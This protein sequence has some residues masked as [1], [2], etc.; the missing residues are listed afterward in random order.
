MRRTGLQMAGAH[1]L[2]QP[3]TE[4]PPCMRPS[5]HDSLDLAERARIRPR[6]LLLPREL[7]DAEMALFSIAGRERRVAA[8]DLIF[9]RGELGR[10]MFVVDSGQ[11]QVEFGDGMPDKLIGP[12]EFFGELA[13]FIG[14]HAR[15]A[16]ARAAN[17]SVLRVIEVERDQRHRTN[18]LAKVRL[19]ALR[20]LPGGVLH[21]DVVGV[22]ASQLAGGPLPRQLAEGRLALGKRHRVAREHRF[23]RVRDR[24][25]VARTLDRGEPLK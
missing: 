25:H 2:K 4:N 17:D 3:G 24:L 1:D 23:Q 15:V 19:E 20:V 16:S 18:V 11:V 21:P 6:P 13:L 7:S 8:G 9:K 10:N 5:T 22:E 14:N 12:R